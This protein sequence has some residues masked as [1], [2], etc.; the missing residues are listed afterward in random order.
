MDIHGKPALMVNVQPD[1]SK[2][3]RGEG[4]VTWLEKLTAFF[5]FVNEVGEG[6]KKNKFGLWVRLPYI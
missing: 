2:R 1:V 5:I 4:I 3:S 6:R